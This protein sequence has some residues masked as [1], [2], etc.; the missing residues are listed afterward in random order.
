[1]SSVTGHLVFG[2]T[3]CDKDDKPLFDL[4]VARFKRKKSAY[5]D[6]LPGVSDEQLAAW[7]EQGVQC[8]L[9]W[10][11]SIG[12]PVHIIAVKAF[13]TYESGFDITF[14]DEEALTK[15]DEYRQ[16]VKSWLE[17]IGVDPSAYKPH[18]FLMGYDDVC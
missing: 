8:E 7:A 15:G 3:D 5:Y 2:F 4:L 6:D 9:V 12:E 13:S 17:S 10:G 1:M 11:A 14:I 18:W 16:V